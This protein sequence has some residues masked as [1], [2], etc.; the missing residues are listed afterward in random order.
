[1]S[2]EDTQDWHMKPSTIKW[3]VGGL[4]AL[5]TAVVGLTLRVGEYVS[6]MDQR[7]T[8]LETKEEASKVSAATLYRRLERMELKLDAAL[9][10]KQP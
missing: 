10:R 5:A 4:F 2:D 8:V 1:M 3:L 9:Q 6:K 7:I